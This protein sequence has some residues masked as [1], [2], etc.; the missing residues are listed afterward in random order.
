MTHYAIEIPNYFG[1]EGAWGPAWAVLSAESPGG[2]RA[3]QAMTTQ[4][5]GRYE[6][7]VDHRS[8]EETRT[9]LHFFNAIGQGKAHSFLLHDSNPG[10]DSGTNEPIGVG[11]GAQVAFQA[12][13]RYTLGAQ[14]YDRVITK[15]VS[16]AVTAYVNGVAVTVA[17]VQAATGVIT[18]AAPAGVGL[19]VSADFQFRVP[20]RFDIDHLR[21]ERVAQ[22]TWSVGRVELMALKEEASV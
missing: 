10:E 21:L 8:R 2:Y 18:L 20:V 11:D 3:T 7:P 19:V 14:S 1:W 16:G 13:K 5:V 9:L 6:L 22:S 15:L 17:S 12:S 4:A